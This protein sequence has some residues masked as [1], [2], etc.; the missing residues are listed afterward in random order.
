MDEMQ[1]RL[2]VGDVRFLATTQKALDILTN[3]GECMLCKDTFY[4]DGKKQ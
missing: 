4:K 2:L 3:W 1:K